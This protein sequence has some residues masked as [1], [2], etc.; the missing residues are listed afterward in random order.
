MVVKSLEKDFNAGNVAEIGDFKNIK[1]FVR[2]IYD[3]SV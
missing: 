3:P 2:V 1:K